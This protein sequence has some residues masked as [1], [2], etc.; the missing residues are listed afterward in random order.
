M[1]ISVY[2]FLLVL[3]VRGGLRLSFVSDYDIYIFLL[4]IFS[5]VIF[6]VSQV[7]NFFQKFLIQP[8][9]NGLLRISVEYGNLLLH[10]E[11]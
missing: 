2:T 9:V 3:S 4:M 7:D 11:L 6:K 10:S 1:F 8:H 5:F